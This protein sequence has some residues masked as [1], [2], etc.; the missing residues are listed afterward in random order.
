MSVLAN[1]RTNN[2]WP[3][4]G[5]LPRGNCLSSVLRYTALLLDDQIGELFVYNIRFLW[6]LGENIIRN[7]LGQLTKVA[8]EVR[9]LGHGTDAMV[10]TRGHDHRLFSTLVE[11][12]VSEGVHVSEAF[13]TTRLHQDDHTAVLQPT[14]EG[15]KYQ[16]ALLL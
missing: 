12:P 2:P 9:V 11:H 5:L 1:H 10:R 13:G 15:I 16:E 3:E 7:L 4:V 6:F 14:P 8:P